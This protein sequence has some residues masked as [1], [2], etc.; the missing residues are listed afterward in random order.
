VPSRDGAQAGRSPAGDGDRSGA[1]AREGREPAGAGG[2]TALRIARKSYLVL[3]VLGVL[4]MLVVV[5]FVTRSE[6]LYALLVML[7]APCVI[8]PLLAGAVIAAPTCTVIARRDRSV[9]RLAAV[10]AVWLVACVGRELLSLPIASR[11]AL[12]MVFASASTLLVVLALRDLVGPRAGRIAAWCFG[13]PLVVEFGWSAGAPLAARRIESGRYV[14]RTVPSTVYAPA[15]TDIFARKAGGGLDYLGSTGT[16]GPPVVLS[17]GLSSG[18]FAIAEDGEAIVFRHVAT[19]GPGFVSRASGLYRH[20]HGGELVLVH[21]EHDLITSWSLPDETLPAGALV[22]DREPAGDM[23]RDTEP[24]DWVAH[25][26]GGEEP[27]GLLGGT[28]LHAAAWRDDAAAVAALVE[29]GAALEA[30]THWQHTALEIALA[31]HREDA[32][33]ALVQRGAELTAFGQ[34][35][36]VTAADFGL[37]RVLEA[38]VARPGDSDPIREYGAAAWR[39]AKEEH[40]ESYSRSVETAKY[41]SDLFGRRTVDSLAAG[42]ERVAVWLREHGVEPAR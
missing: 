38:I 1:P 30:R 12:D 25:A 28:A 13:L 37:L 39:A 19:L 42:R 24:T 31:R 40:L 11:L 18:G 22:F 17:L 8:L 20:A 2:S 34:H 14:L 3:G 9:R 41:D 26:D 21:P 4:H 10:A 35:A 27:L 23:D 29:E 16:V 36:F 5:P 32:A 33:V 6:G 7:I 15:R